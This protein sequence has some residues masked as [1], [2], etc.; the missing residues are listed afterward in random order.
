MNHSTHEQSFISRIIDT[1][2]PARCVVCGRRLD[3][4]NTLIC[5]FCDEE[6]PRTEYWLKPYD[7]PMSRMFWGLI[8]IEKC[9][10]MFFYQHLSVYTR[11]IKDF[12]YHN[13][14]E[15]ARLFGAIMAR[16]MEPCGFFDGIDGIMPLPLARNRERKRGYNQCRELA[17]GLCD[18]TM[19]PM[20]D[21]V[22]ARNKFETSQTHLG[23]YDRFNNV[24]GMFRVIKPAALRDHHVLMVDDVATTGASIISCAQTMQSVTNVKVSVLTASFTKH[25]YW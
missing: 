21:H 5:D 24:E 11:I 4:A 22:V 1:I 20:I 2:A 25:R 12:K 15:H 19:L 16:E 17:R 13:Q 10:A 8:M 23:R 6:L 18:V 7:N 9:A 3:D 14:P